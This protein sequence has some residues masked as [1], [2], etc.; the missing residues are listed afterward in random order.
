MNII[1]YGTGQAGRIAYHKLE[2]EHKIFAFCDSNKECWGKTVFEKLIISP[3][4]A[5]NADEVNIVVASTY[6]EE[7]IEGLLKDGCEYDRIWFI[8]PDAWILEKIDKMGYYSVS[9]TNTKMKVLFVQAISG[10]RIDKIAFV[11][12]SKG[13]QSDLA[14]LSAP[15]EMHIGMNSSPYNKII[16]INDLV[17]FIKYVNESDY[18]L[19]FS[20][21]EPDYLT[22]LLLQS[23]KKVIH[24]NADMTSLYQDV[25]ISDLIHE[26]VANKM[27][28]GNIYVTEA[29]KNIAMKKYDLYGKK[30]FLLNNYVLKKAKPTI[31]KKKLSSMDSELHC[32][33]EGGYISSEPKHFRYYEDMFMAIAKQG[34]HVHFYAK[35]LSYFDEMCSKNKYIHY[36]GCLDYEVLQN[37]LT[38][39]DIGLV[40]INITKRNEAFLQTTFPNKIFEYLFARLPVAVS[41]IENTINFVKTYGVGDYLDFDQD[42]KAQLK[43]IACC[44]VPIDFLE[45]NKLTMDDQ[46]DNILQFFQDIINK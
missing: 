32:V 23:N 8:R 6:Y 35:Y 36:E 5:I 19:V 12:K 41:R 37:E 11:I 17:E 24:D 16:P 33:Y 46:A 31:F 22:T 1:I 40:F 14:Y 45:S 26:Y 13:V 3:K 18:D 25:P 9:K 34:I 4:E 7:I 21:N 38:K 2:S 29:I 43:N 39:Y 15:P 30:I 44:D 27:S 20:A 28:D 10:I 42:I